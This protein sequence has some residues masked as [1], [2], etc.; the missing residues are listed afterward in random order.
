M[1]TFGYP[2]ALALATV[3][4]GCGALVGCADPN[5]GLDDWNDPW[6]S[7]YSRQP[8]Y[9]YGPN[10]GYAR[11]NDNDADG[12]SRARSACR[13]AAAERGVR[14]VDIEDV[15]SR[16]GDYRVKLKGVTPEGK[17]VIRCDYDRQDRFARVFT[18]PQ[19]GGGPSV[20]DPG[21]V[22]FSRARRACRQAAVAQGL[23][24][25]DVSGTRPSGR[26][27]AQ[28]FLDG[29]RNDGRRERV[30]CAYD[31]SSGQADLGR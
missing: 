15:D 25:V 3:L 11:L 18:P 26:G 21:R 22:D 5:Y 19:W 28:V 29:R 14:V 4:V 6:A 2:L 17:T 12:A 13:Q 16:G 7:S 1:R 9:A 10:Y 31:G 24:R 23:R 27:G 30:S 8:S 20:Y